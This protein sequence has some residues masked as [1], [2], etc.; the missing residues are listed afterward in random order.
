MGVGNVKLNG[1]TAFYGN[2][3]NSFLQASV[4]LPTLDQDYLKYRTHLSLVWIL[5]T[6][7]WRLVNRLIEFQVCSSFPGESYP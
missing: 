1:I 5:A 7:F 6:D 2:F 4:A 3:P